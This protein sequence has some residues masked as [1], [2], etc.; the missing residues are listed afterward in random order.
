[1]S[2]Q[3][4][5]VELASE[6]FRDQGLR[7][8][9]CRSLMATDHDLANHASGSDPGPESAEILTQNIRILTA[10]CLQRMNLIDHGLCVGTP[11]AIVL[12]VLTELIN[13]DH[14][15]LNDLLPDA[16]RE[17]KQRRWKDLS[18]LSQK[19]LGWETHLAALPKGPPPTV[20]DFQRVRQAGLDNLVLRY[21]WL[22]NVCE[23]LPPEQQAMVFPITLEFPEGIDP[24]KLFLS[25][26]GRECEPCIEHIQIVRALSR[27]LSRSEATLHEEFLDD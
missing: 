1:M 4:H 10:I 16:S 21:S 23:Q 15:I 13:V 25:A 2:N 24:S 18:A 27:S 14:N 3:L 11:D 22:A 5:G 20:A 8:V 7:A 6:A 12:K 9:W 17:V 19:M 26:D